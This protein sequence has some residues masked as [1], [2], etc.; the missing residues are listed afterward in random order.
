[1][2]RQSVNTTAA[3]AREPEQ[4]NDALTEQVWV[5]MKPCDSTQVFDAHS[6]NVNAGE[7]MLAPVIAALADHISCWHQLAALVC[8]A[9]VGHYEASNNIQAAERYT[10]QQHHTPDHDTEVDHTDTATTF[11][12]MTPASKIVTQC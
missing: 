3:A 8:Q 12:F 1:M 9:G 4:A 2:P 10:D 7:I 6:N 5:F 11:S